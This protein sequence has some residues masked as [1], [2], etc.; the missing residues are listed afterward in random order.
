M[1][2]RGV[3]ALLHLRKPEGVER[4]KLPLVLKDPCGTCTVGDQ[5]GG[6]WC[7]L[8]DMLVQY[9]DDFSHGLLP[10]Y[11]VE[12]ID[13][14]QYWLLASDLLVPD[15]RQVDDGKL[16]EQGEFA[17]RVN[18]RLGKFSRVPVFLPVLEVQ[19]DR[20]R[21]RVR[22]KACEPAGHHALA[23]ASRGFEHETSRPRC[24]CDQ[25]RHRKQLT[26]GRGDGQAK[27]G[28]G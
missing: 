6:V 8:T 28:K 13:D 18:F 9:I 7:R 1:P 4:G 21:T 12:T 14:E 23:A 20:H 11:L 17:L 27:L 16:E 5:H 3:N 10:G 25:F 2:E 24:F 19:H 26:I 15:E 22:H